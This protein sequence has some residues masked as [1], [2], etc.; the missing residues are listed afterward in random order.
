MVWEVLMR[1]TKETSM[2]WRSRRI[3]REKR[4][5]DCLYHLLCTFL[6]KKSIIIASLTIV[7]KVSLLKLF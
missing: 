3:L 1:M 2:I 7:G 6:V 4:R 5:N